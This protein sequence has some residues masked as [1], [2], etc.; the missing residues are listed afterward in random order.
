MTDKDQRALEFLIKVREKIDEIT[1]LAEEYNLSEDFIAA[2][3]VGVIK[4]T[5][6]DGSFH[7]IDAITSIFADN[8]EE[9]ASVLYH[10]SQSFVDD[11]NESDSRD[12]DFWL[13]FGDDN[14]N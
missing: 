10:M 11:D 7:R 2:I 6:E 1:D 3:S 9:L 12:I 14:I 5:T 13:N 4:E 8:E